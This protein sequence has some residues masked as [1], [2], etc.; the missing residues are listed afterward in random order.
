MPVTNSQRVP[1][2][3]EGDSLTS[4]WP[5]DS[6]MSLEVAMWVT[7]AATV[8]LAAFAVVTAWFARK[9]FLKQ[10]EEVA[11]IEQQVSD[12]KDLAASQAEML[13][14]QAG[15]LR[16]AAAERD[17]E[18]LERRRAQAAGVYVWEASTQAEVGGHAIP[19]LTVEVYIRNRSEQ[20]VYD[21]R[22][23]WHIL[24][25]DFS[26]FVEESSYHEPILM[27]GA[28]TR[29]RPAGELADP[30]DATAVVTFRDRVGVWWRAWPDGRLEDLPADPIDGAPVP[31]T[32]PEMGQ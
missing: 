15:E 13:G 9:A 27:P 2:K 14:L 24:T 25:A 22:V 31:E 20:P 32:A 17:R 10:S 29:N 5:Y 18:A 19:E 3:S 28:E 23:E 12:Q 30:S 26:E 21:L 4:L 7:A 1:G 6:A 8:V 16:R 11:A